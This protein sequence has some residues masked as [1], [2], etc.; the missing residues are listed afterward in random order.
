MQ[1]ALAAHGLDDRADSALLEA[2]RLGEADS[3]TDLLPSII[4][5]TAWVQ[6]S[7]RAG[8]Q[9]QCDARL[10]AIVDLC[11]ERYP[12]NDWTHVWRKVTTY[13]IPLLKAKALKAG[14]SS[15]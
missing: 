6:G 5:H 2:Y 1:A 14:E 4:L 10:Q 15:W 11:K 9:E 3:E 12:K 13:M 8:V 7:Y